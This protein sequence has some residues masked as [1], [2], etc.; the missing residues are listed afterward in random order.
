[1]FRDVVFLNEDGT[2]FNILNVRSLDV[3]NDM[4]DYKDKLWFDYTDWEAKPG[5]QSTYNKDTEEWTHYAPPSAP[6]VIPEHLV[7]IDEPAVD[8]LAGG[9]E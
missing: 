1:M 9:N 5:P 7:P 4:P 2:V 3:I 6:P 8:E